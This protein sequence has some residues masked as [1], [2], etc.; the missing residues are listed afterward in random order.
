MD[1]IDPSKETE[2]LR[3]TGKKKKKIKGEFHFRFKETYYKNR[4][5]YETSYLDGNQESS[6]LEILKKKEDKYLLW[7]EKPLV[8][9]LFDSKRWNRP[10]R[11]IKNDRVENAMSN[12][13]I[14]FSCTSLWIGL[15]FLVGIFNSLIS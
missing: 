15:V 5:V 7:I 6:K 1:M 9:L 12:K 8:T 11:Y 2:K 4:P 3:V 14:V 10:L 13:N